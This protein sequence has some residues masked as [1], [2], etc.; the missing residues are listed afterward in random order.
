MSALPEAIEEHPSI[1]D[2]LAAAKRAC[3]H[4][5][6]SLAARR[7]MRQECLAVP[8]HLRAGLI[9]HFEESYP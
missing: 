6:D 7:Q 4:W 8:P 9:Q 3:D 2:L 1:Q 5:G